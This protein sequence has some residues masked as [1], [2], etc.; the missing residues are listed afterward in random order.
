MTFYFIHQCFSQEDVKVK[1]TELCTIC[2]RRLEK[3]TL[4]DADRFLPEHIECSLYDEN[5]TVPVEKSSR[6]DIL[7]DCVAVF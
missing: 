6:A 2:A 5:C 4:S 7:L 3:L 1:Q